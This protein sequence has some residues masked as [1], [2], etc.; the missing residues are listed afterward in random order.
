ML[1]LQTTFATNWSFSWSSNVHEFGCQATT[2]S[3]GS[4]KNALSSQWKRAMQCRR[5]DGAC[6]KPYGDIQQT[7]LL[8]AAKFKLNDLVCQ[9][10]LSSR[11]NIANIAPGAR[12][13]H[14]LV[15][16]EGVFMHCC[17]DVATCQSVAS[18]QQ[19]R[20]LELCYV[21][22]TKAYSCTRA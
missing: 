21:G 6:W 2:S 18:L 8:L 11:G 5:R 17:I 4:T 15:V 12:G 14:D 1:E 22:K 16:Y 7:D 3:R 19:H 20:Q 13:E 9:P 10:I